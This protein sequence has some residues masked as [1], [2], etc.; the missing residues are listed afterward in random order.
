MDS[1]AGYPSEAVDS[2]YLKI[3]KTQLHMVLNNLALI[4][5]AQ[6]GSWT[7]FPELPFQLDGSE[8]TKNLPV[9]TVY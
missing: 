4:D 3:L 8:L 9:N 6:A 5:Y 1:E 7:R 2:P